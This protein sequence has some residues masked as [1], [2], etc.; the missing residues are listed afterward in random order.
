[1]K[2]SPAML[3]KREA[4]DKSILIVS[5]NFQV[6]KQIQHPS[7]TYTKAAAF[8]LY[9]SNNYCTLAALSKFNSA[10]TTYS[11]LQFRCFHF[12]L[13]YALEVHLCKSDRHTHV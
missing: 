5:I 8:Y 3:H 4:I 7:G 2:S 10:T 9:K 1:M 11:P 6:C 12:L 13:Y